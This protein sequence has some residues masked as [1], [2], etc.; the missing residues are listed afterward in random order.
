MKKTKIFTKWLPASLTLLMVSFQAQA[1]TLSPS[2]AAGTVSGNS[3]LNAVSDI[4]SAFGTYF[5]ALQLLWKSG[6]GDQSG[7]L[8]DS[9][10]LNVDLSAKGGSIDLLS[11]QDGA[12]CPT[13]ILV[14]DDPS[15]DAQYLVELGDWDGAES[16][17]LEEFGVGEDD[18]S[19]AI[20]GGEA[21]SVPEPSVLMLMSLGLL[22]L[23]YNSKRKLA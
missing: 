21:A 14:V 13:C 18:S 16:I 10:E 17:E 12:S 8:A 9:Y 15:E 3:N 11:G 22:G 6:S 7:S 4:N 5:S 23:V 20:W 19:V 1:L 2:D